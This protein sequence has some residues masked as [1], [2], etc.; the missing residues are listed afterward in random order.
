MNATK[1]IIVSSC[2]LIWNGITNPCFSQFNP[3]NK[4]SLQITKA[5]QD[6]KSN[7]LIDTP[8]NNN[9]PIDKEV[10]GE[11]IR[12]FIYQAKRNYYAYYAHLYK[13]PSITKELDSLENV[14][15]E[16]LSRNASK[17]VTKEQKTRALLSLGQFYI[18]NER[19]GDTTYIIRIQKE[20][21]DIGHKFPAIVPSLQLGF[22]RGRTNAIDASIMIGY[23][24]RKNKSIKNNYIYNGILFGGELYSN[25]I[26]GFKF[27]AHFN[28]YKGLY[29][30][31][32]YIPL[33]DKEN[34]DN[35]QNTKN[36]KNSTV[37]AS[38]IRFETGYSTEYGHIYF[39]ATI[40]SIN[41]AIDQQIQ[42]RINAAY[43]PIQLGIRF[44]LPYLKLTEISSTKIQREKLRA[45]YSPLRVAP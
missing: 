19:Y 14:A 5:Y 15:L 21:N 24:C 38:F 20:L 25:N 42:T 9:E 31:V 34:N 39:G 30:A 4:D 26:S 1:T 37:L 23:M 16:L 7:M 10:E 41:S 29:A 44:Q 40:K 12:E 8:R 11:K 35:T 27:G 28:I 43:N 13:I 3:A 22:A 6:F 17:A 33:V 36:N 32:H 2:L 45:A 18:E